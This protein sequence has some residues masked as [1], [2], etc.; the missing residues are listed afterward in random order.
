MKR[1]SALMVISAL[2]QISCAEAGAAQILRRYTEQLDIP[3]ENKIAAL[4][5]N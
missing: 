1:P 5:C 4:K 2:K 3:Y